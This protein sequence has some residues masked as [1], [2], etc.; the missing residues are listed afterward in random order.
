MIEE[1]INAVGNIMVTLSAI[2]PENPAL[3][4]LIL[5]LIPGVFIA[6]AFISDK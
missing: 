4:L 2:M 1:A 3:G 5:A 6:G